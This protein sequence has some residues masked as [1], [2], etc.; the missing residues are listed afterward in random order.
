M[1][2]DVAIFQHHT[3][4][5][6]FPRHMRMRYVGNAA[7]IGDTRNTYKILC[8]QSGGKRPLEKYNG[9]NIKVGQSQ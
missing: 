3:E 1:F 6:G 5:S 7:C 2:K 8:R 4:F 9:G